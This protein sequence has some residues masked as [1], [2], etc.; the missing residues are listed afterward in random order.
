MSK[1]SNEL[2]AEIKAACDEL[3]R[4]D[5]KPEYVNFY[6]LSADDLATELDAVARQLETRKRFLGVN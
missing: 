1:N 4:L 6:R 3:R 2:I 5:V